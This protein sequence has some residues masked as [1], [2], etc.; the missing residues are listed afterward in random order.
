MRWGLIIVPV[1]ALEATSNAFV[2]H[3]WGEYLRRQEVRSAANSAVPNTWRDVIFVA[4]PALVS[5]AIALLVE[6]P[7]CL[8]LSFGGVE[9]FARYLSASE[10]VA[11]ITANMWRTID[12]CYIM[13]AVSTCLSTILLATRPCWYLVHSLITNVDYCLP[14]AIVLSQV[15]I[16]PDNA[17]KYHAV[18]FV[19]P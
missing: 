6:V 12:W 3:R 17:W 2:G 18:I 8:A 4:R 11:K 16:N 9:P 7:M 1:S 13:Y 10:E 19:S 15:N 5:T 14:W